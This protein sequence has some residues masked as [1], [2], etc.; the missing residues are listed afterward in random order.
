MLLFT[1]VTIVLP[2]LH[3][4]NLDYIYYNHTL[5]PITATTTIIIVRGIGQ[6]L[7]S[8]HFVLTKQYTKTVT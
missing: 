2:F 6:D 3:Q 5:L 1:L 8:A 4:T 7:L